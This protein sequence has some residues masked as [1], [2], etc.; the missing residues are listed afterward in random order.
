MKL[1]DVAEALKLPHTIFALPFAYLG[2]WAAANGFPGWQWFGW[3]TLAMVGARTAGMAWNRLL[4]LP[5][6][7]LNPRT[8]SWPTAAGRVTP[9][10]L[11]AL[12]LAATALFLYSAARLNPL[13]LRLTP[14]ALAGLTLYP[15]LKR[16]T[17]ACHFGLGL[18][19]GM[20]PVGGWLAVTGAWD[21]RPLWLLAAVALWVA[22]FDIVYSA[23]DIDFDRAHRL[24]SIP[25]RFGIVSALRAARVGHAGMVIVLGAFGVATHRAGLFWLGWL[26]VAILLHYEHQ[27]VSPSDLRRVN[28]AFF[29][30]NGWVSALLLVTTALD[31][32]YPWP[33]PFWR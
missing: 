24:Y 14:V 25:Q 2:G 18:V 30:I 32:R 27:L 9:P 16:F 17:W 12:A 6:D 11:L 3:V 1:R 33:L 31:C 4:D 23:L 20:A 21:P 13:C 22:G 15:F 5:F 19:L 8:A 26:A 7:R 10:I 29:V 28:Q